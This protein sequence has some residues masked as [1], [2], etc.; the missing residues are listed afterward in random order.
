LR[1]SWIVCYGLLQDFKRVCQ[2]VHGTRRRSLVCVASPPSTSGARLSP[3]L[4]KQI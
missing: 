3:F 2:G 1:S 4:K